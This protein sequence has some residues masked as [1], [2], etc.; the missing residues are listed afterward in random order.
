MQ[1]QEKADE[2]TPCKTT[3]LVSLI[4]DQ[5]TSR[6]NTTRNAVDRLLSDLFTLAHC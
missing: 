3:E 6:N 4:G 1:S 2:T 5:S